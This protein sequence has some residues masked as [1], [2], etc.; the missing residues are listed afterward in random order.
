[1]KIKEEQVKKDR[2]Q[3]ELRQKM[4][5]EEKRKVEVARE[6]IQ[7]VENETIS[8]EAD[9]SQ[10]KKPKLPAPFELKKE[11]EIESNMALDLS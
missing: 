6:F 2:E 1:M 9:V 5:K 4:M 10:E 3:F 8:K 11:L 7:K